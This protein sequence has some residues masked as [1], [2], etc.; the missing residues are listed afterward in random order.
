MDHLP[1]VLNPFEPL[2]IPYLGGTEVGYD[3]LGYEGYPSRQ[4]WDV[5]LLKHGDLQGRT[6]L[7]AAHFLQDWLYFGMLRETL[8]AV[9]DDPPLELDGLLRA[10]QTTKQTLVTTAELADLLQ[11]LYRRLEQ[12]P[13]TDEYYQRFRNCMLL[14]CGVWQD[15]MHL[16][17]NEG[18]S[19]PQ[20]LSHEILLSIQVL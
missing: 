8:R 13:S 2:D 20:I 18:V 1:P 14:S 19:G 17:E 10:E 12:L 7:E 16:C 9:P 5:D 3:G 15:L 6:I 11:D 4:G